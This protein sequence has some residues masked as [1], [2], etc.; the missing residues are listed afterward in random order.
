MKSRCA[1]LRQYHLEVCD[2]RMTDLSGN[3]LILTGPPGAGK[4]TTARSLVM[5][6]DGP[7]VHLHSDD[8][9]HF[10]KKGAIPPY[11]PEAHK[12]NEV[13]MAVLAEAGDGYARGNYFVVVDGIVGPW[14]LSS[15]TRLNRPLHYVVLRPAVDVAIERCRLR[16][17]ST[18]SDPEPITALHKQF[19]LL[20]E[21][22]KH[23]IETDGLS[24]DATVDAVKNDL[25]R[26]SP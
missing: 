22:E 14:F 10:I 3:I 18:L 19:S 9:W 15:F 16:G 4:T 12:Q 6:S 21:L 13:V 1:E 17:G 24:P 5:V 26:C 11:L 2:F 8:F 20:G 25:V 23:V 7:A